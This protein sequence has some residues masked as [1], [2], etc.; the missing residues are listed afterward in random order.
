MTHT[1]Q[2]NFVIF[3]AVLR[4]LVGSDMGKCYSKKWYI[5]SNYNMTVNSRLNN[6]IIIIGHL[7]TESNTSF[8]M[9][10]DIFKFFK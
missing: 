3:I 5:N 2:H 9:L 7:K 6:P 8:K 1:D 10:S 4:V